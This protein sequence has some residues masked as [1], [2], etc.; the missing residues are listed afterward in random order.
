M[1]AATGKPFLSGRVEKWLTHQSH[2]LE[3]VGSNPTSAPKG[4]PSPSDQKMGIIWGGV[5]AS[6]GTVD[7]AVIPRVGLSF[8]LLP[9][10]ASLSVLD[11]KN[12]LYIWA[13]NP[14]K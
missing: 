8:H 10:Q 6:R 5:C 14:L 11:I 7:I 12:R 3:I 4:S 2:K 13:S 1:F 9:F